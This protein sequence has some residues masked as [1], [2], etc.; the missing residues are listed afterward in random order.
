MIHQL[1]WWTSVLT[2][3]VPWN[4]RKGFYQDSQHVESDSNW[5]L[6]WR[7]THTHT[8]KPTPTHIKILWTILL[9]SGWCCSGNP[10]SYTQILRTEGSSASHLLQECTTSGEPKNYCWHSMP[11]SHADSY[12]LMVWLKMFDE[13]GLLDKK[14]VS[15]YVP[16]L[17]FS[18]QILG[19]RFIDI[20]SQPTVGCHLV[21]FV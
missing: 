9:V 8:P 15:K 11:I 1:R 17:L 20:S 6:I 7:R 10:W 2:L 19:H 14:L 3:G 4:Q 21:S 12:G 5:Y 18:I 16:K 13:L